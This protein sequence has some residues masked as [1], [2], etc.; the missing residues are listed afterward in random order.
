[1]HKLPRTSVKAV[2]ASQGPG[3]NTAIKHEWTRQSYTADPRL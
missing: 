1:M 3:P 2:G